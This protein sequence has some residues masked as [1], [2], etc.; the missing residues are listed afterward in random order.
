MKLSWLTRVRRYAESK[1][2]CCWSNR[3]TPRPARGTS[4]SADA[5]PS[6]MR[7]YWAPPPLANNGGQISMGAVS[8]VPTHPSSGFDRGST[9]SI[10]VSKSTESTSRLKRLDFQ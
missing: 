5:V 9:N 8:A 2:P 3:D 10:I 6:R 1:V 4:F 7:I